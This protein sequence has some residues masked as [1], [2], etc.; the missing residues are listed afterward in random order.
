MLQ[1]KRRLRNKEYHDRGYGKESLFGLFTPND[2]PEHPK[3]GQHARQADDT[4]MDQL[5]DILVVKII[6]EKASY[7]P[8]GTLPRVADPHVIVDIFLIQQVLAVAGTDPE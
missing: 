5:L 4:G 8:V 6:A 3:D 7:V 1:G 2:L